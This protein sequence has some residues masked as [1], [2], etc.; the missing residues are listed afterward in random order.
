MS[1]LDHQANVAAAWL[2]FQL[3][4]C[5]NRQQ[6]MYDCP[7]RL[8]REKLLVLSLATDG[9]GNT[10]GVRTGFSSSSS[11]TPW[12]TV[13]F[14]T[15]LPV[16]STTSTMAGHAPE[17]GTKCL[18][19]PGGTGLVS[20]AVFLRKNRIFYFMN[21]IFV[22][23]QLFITKYLLGW[24]KQKVSFKNVGMKMKHFVQS[25][26]IKKIFSLEILKVLHLI[27]L[28]TIFFLFS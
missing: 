5:W 22:L 26:N 9:T 25:K 3:L 8:Y 16:C 4:G 24:F 2:L 27:Q 1:L 18:W 23:K 11:L 17:Q 6:T 20:Q 10:L 12:L 28:K 19:H 7:L 21:F 13:H 14:C 15:E